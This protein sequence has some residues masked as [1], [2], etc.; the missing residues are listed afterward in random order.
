MTYLFVGINPRWQAYKWLPD[1]LNVMYSAGGAW[2]N[3]ARQ[4]RVR[5]FPKKSGSRWLDCGGFTMLNKHGDY[6]FSLDTFANFVAAVQPDYYTSP[7]YPCEPEITRSLRL[8]TNL[9]RIE[10]TVETSV[11]WVSDL[12]MM[13]SPRSQ[14][15]PTIQGWALEE[16]KR[17]LD[18]YAEAGLI[19]GYMAVGSMCTRSNSRQIGEIVQGVHRHAQQ[20]GVRRL[21][22]FGLKMS[23]ELDGL[24][25]YIWSRDSAAALFAG[26]ATLKDKWGGRWPRTVAHRR[27]AFVDFFQR[28]RNQEIV[29]SLEQQ[30]ICPVCHSYQVH[31][32]TYSWPGCLCADCGHNWG[33]IEDYDLD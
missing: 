23:R 21:H 4:F 20:L 19:R 1:G 11:S 8:A 26:N 14:M 32:P 33:E 15:V 9:C 25:P 5:R 17:C 13:L 27:E 28:A 18:L 7:D 31:L 3:A 22:F 2:D 29:Y 10:K 24:Q 16:Y 12:E 30:D 6:P